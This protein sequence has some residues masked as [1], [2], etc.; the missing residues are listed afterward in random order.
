MTINGV[1]SP[2][3]NMV[4]MAAQ[5]GG[6]LLVSYTGKADDYGV[7]NIQFDNR[8]TD[9]FHLS[10]AANRYV[11]AAETAYNI[12]LQA[13]F[14]NNDGSSIYGT[15]PEV[16][17]GQLASKSWVKR[18]FIDNLDTTYDQYDIKL[19][20]N[21][22][23]AIDY[24]F[25][26]DKE[27]ATAEEIV[28]TNYG[29]S[30]ITLS[31]DLRAGNTG[32]TYSKNAR[33]VGLGFFDSKI[34]TDNGEV[35]RGFAG[36][37][38]DASGNLYYYE[39][40]TN[41]LDKAQFQA[42]AWGTDKANGGGTWR[43][44]AWTNVAIDLELIDDGLKAKI[45]GVHVVGS[46][47]DY[48][49]LIG[50]VFNTTDMIGFTA[51]STTSNTNG[52]VDNVQ[53]IVREAATPETW[54]QKFE[55]YK[56]DYLAAA[57]PDLAAATSFRGENGTVVP[58]TVLDIIDT[59]SPNVWKKRGMGE[60]Y[61]NLDGS[62]TGNPQFTI[63]EN[64]AK[65]G[66]NSGIAADWDKAE[67]NSMTLSV[68]LQ[69]NT[70]SG[71]DYN[72][73]ARGLGMGFFKKGTENGFYDNNKEVAQGF[74]GI[75][76]SPNGGLYYYDFTSKDNQ[77]Y[78]TPIAFGGTFDRNEWYTLTMNLEFFHEGNTLMAMLT[79]VSLSGSNADYSSLIGSVFSTTD[80]IGLLSSAND[81]Q[82]YGM[83]DNFSMS[84]TV[85]EPSTWA[86][87]ILGAAGLLYMR[88]R[89]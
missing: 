57:G 45:T 49:A 87:L 40:L 29:A 85:P 56:A 74:S 47:A 9:T 86:L 27:S 59:K 8:N 62:R 68:D 15:T 42:V 34:G 71:S 28:G 88:K 55:Q 6:G 53:L 58:G 83:F 78:T 72:T 50:K 76:V 16:A 43:A 46:S 23:A 84:K 18:G 80:F 60:G 22:G 10:A 63:I 4:D 79:D 51:S 20:H 2:L 14:N 30:K 36:L 70:L 31:A 3:I 25:T 61:W 41:N 52:F 5:E 24:N 32:G 13:R 17:L 67:V 19:I 37:V 64:Q 81:W 65:T 26:G 82:Y 33:G 75:A 73:S 66:A 38:L 48:S 35:G 77:N 21:N 69:M 12:P 54:N 11:S 39:N 89:K 44:D 1:T 7:I